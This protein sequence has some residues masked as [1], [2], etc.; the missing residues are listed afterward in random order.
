MNKKANNLAESP[1]FYAAV[2]LVT[3]LLEQGVSVPDISF[4]LAFVATDLGIQMAP[5]TAHAIAV[6]MDAV[7]KSTAMHAS[8]DQQSKSASDVDVVGDKA[9]PINAEVFGRTIH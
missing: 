8:T 7:R 1:P 4:A 5:S 6:V 2:E 3:N 9:S